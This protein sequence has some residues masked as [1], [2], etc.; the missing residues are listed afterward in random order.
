MENEESIVYETI[1]KLIIF[2]KGTYE[3]ISKY[4]QYY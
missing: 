1:T 3:N 4:K 2:E